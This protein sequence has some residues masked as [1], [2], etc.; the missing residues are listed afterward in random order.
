MDRAKQGIAPG[1]EVSVAYGA[2]DFYTEAEYV[3]DSKVGED[4]FTYAWSELGFSPRNWLRLGVVGQRTRVYQSDRD[5]QRGVFGQAVLGEI[6]LG[7]TA[8]GRR[9][10]GCGGALDQRPIASRPR[11]RHSR[12]SP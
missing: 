12:S 7:G 11:T 5:I 10:E 6:T 9:F 2:V 8:P 3:H 1:F 4:S